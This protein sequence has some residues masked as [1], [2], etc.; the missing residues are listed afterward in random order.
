MPREQNE[1]AFRELFQHR[2]YQ[3][4]TVSRENPV[5]FSA[6]PAAV[7][8]T[9]QDIGEKLAYSSNFDQAAILGW[10][11]DSVAKFAYDES[12]VT[13]SERIA[14]QLPSDVAGHVAGVLE[15]LLREILQAHPAECK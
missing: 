12:W 11:A 3:R 14:K 15:V 4:E 10:W 9:A 13:Q 5:M 8:L 1:P 7:V 6:N 2:R